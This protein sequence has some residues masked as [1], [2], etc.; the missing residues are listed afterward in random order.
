MTNRENAGPWR[1]VRHPP[2]GWLASWLS[3]TSPRFR[4][5]SERGSRGDSR[6]VRQPVNAWAS[7]MT[8]CPGSASYALRGPRTATF[9]HQHEPAQVRHVRPGK[10]VERGPLTICSRRPS[11]T[12]RVG[13]VLRRRLTWPCRR[14][15]RPCKAQTPDYRRLLAS[16]SP[17]T[18]RALQWCSAAG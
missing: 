14:S 10:V 7:S 6:L 2:R 12:P 15:S 16:Y 9:L 11:V 3:S 4:P 1:S 13:H 18:V 8:D 17:S 5:A